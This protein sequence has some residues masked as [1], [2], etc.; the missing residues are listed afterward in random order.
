MGEVVHKEACQEKAKVKMRMKKCPQ[1][2]K[3]YKMKEL[4]FRVK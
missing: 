4:D 1:N 3:K 2:K